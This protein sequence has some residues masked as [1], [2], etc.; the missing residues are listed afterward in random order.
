M[1]E[2]YVKHICVYGNMVLQIY[3]KKLE[4]RQGIIMPETYY[5]IDVFDGN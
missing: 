4:K 3:E 5:M 2:S 1:Y